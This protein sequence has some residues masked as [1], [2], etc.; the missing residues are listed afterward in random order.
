LYFYYLGYIDETIVYDDYL[1]RDFILA[2]L[3][4]K[5]AYRPNQIEVVNMMPLYPTGTSMSQYD[6]TLIHTC[7]YY[8]CRNCIMGYKFD[9]FG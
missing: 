2:V 8:N 5:L 3:I 6:V 4:D 7:I 1:T 9:S